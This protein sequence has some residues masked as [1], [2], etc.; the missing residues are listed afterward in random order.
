MGVNVIL[1]KISGIREE[2]LCIS[3]LKVDLAVLHLQSMA[4]AVRSM[5]RILM[6]KKEGAEWRQAIWDHQEKE[7][8]V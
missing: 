2:K 4:E 1:L 8:L 3:H 5:L 7:V 6:E